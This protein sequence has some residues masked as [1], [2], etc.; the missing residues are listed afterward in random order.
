MLKVSFKRFAEAE[1][2]TGIALLLASE[3]SSYMTGQT[4]YFDGGVM[5]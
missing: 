3:A 5:L 2:I 4:V 1:E